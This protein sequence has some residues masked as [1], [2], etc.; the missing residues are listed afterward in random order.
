[1]PSHKAVSI[2]LAVV[3]FN[4]LSGSIAYIK[5]KRVDFKTG[6]KFIVFAAPGA[7]IGT[8]LTVY[9]HGK[10]FRMIFSFLLLLVVYRM[11][12]LPMWKKNRTD[13]PKDVTVRNIVDARGISYQYSFSQWKGNLLS[14]F[15]GTYSGLFGVG[16]GILHVPIMVGILSFPVHI[17]TATSHFVLVITSLVSTIESIMLGRLDFD[18]VLY[19]A[20]GVIIGAQVGAAISPK[21][22]DRFLKFIL[23]ILLVITSVKMLVV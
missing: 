17:A 13:L 9:L 11:L 21:V 16:G 18:Y 6:W 10:T 22:N 1:M 3:F 12:G 23:A 15:V 20:I 14:F 5:Q 4:A 8:Y 19:L 7:L 2:S